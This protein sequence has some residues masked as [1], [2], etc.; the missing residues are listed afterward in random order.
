MKNIV[1]AVTGVWLLSGGAGLGF[2]QGASAQDADRTASAGMF[3]RIAEV[4]R[5]PRCMNCHTV[6]EFPRQGDTRHRHQQMVM[7]GPDGHGTATMQC[8]NCHQDTNS[9]DGRIPGALHWHLAPLSMAWEHLK[10][11]SELCAA[12]LDTKLN[13][14]RD[15]SAI[16]HHL[17]TDPLVQWAWA[18]GAR[19]PPNMGRQ[20]FH[21][22]AK[23]WAE[24]GAAC[25]T[26]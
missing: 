14:G 7:R 20:E 3:K 9:G 15:V 2:A 4:L 21:A 18:P 13:G 12:F 11:D 26:E 6:T 19:K 10:T 16:V 25:P 24:T 5:H 17:T 23:R 1:A 8:S 22:L